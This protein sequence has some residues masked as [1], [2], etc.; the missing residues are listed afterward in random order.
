MIFAALGFQ[1]LE[2]QLVLK[3]FVAKLRMCINKI[4]SDS[5]QKYICIFKQWFD[6]EL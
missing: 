3:G 2:Y 4:D 6:T 1:I 5:E